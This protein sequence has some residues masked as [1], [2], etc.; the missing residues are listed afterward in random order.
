VAAAKADALKVYAG[1]LAAYAKA[2]ASGTWDS[3]DIDKYAADPL[4]QQAHIQLKDLADSKLAMTGR[5]GSHPVV[6]A[7]NVA[8]NPHSVLISDCVDMANW[9]EVDKSTGRAPANVNQPAFEAFSLVVVAYPTFGW[10]VQQSNR[11]QAS[12]C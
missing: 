5:P 2:A 12:R 8:T 11:A 3:T 6:T 7:V 1:Y 4:R 9:K 10:L